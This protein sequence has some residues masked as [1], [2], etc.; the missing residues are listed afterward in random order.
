MKNSG[1]TIK[2]RTKTKIE[3]K[4]RTLINIIV[5]EWKI[6]F[7][8]SLLSLLCHSPQ[9]LHCICISTEQ[10]SVGEH[11]S[12]KGD[13]IVLKT[14]LVHLNFYSRGEKKM[15]KKIC[16]Y[17]INSVSAFLNMLNAVFETALALKF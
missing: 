11:R 12:V 13:L 7:S 14:V 6:C 2:I 10:P 16:Q 9:G 8:S 15:K 5:T 4:I 17:K 1:G 3:S